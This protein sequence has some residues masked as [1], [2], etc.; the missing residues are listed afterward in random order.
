MRVYAI[1]TRTAPSNGHKRDHELLDSSVAIN[2]NTQLVLLRPQPFPQPRPEADVGAHKVAFANAAHS[3]KLD[4][5]RNVADS[6]T[7]KPVAEL[8]QR[9]AVSLLA[10]SPFQRVSGKSRRFSWS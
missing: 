7:C 4:W 2:S 3:G 5:V 6:I 9:C 1:C 10:P 8:A